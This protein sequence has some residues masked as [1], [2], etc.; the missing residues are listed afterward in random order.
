MLISFVLGTALANSFQSPRSGPLLELGTGPGFAEGRLTS[1]SHIA[2]G[3]WFGRYDDEYALGRFTAI[4]LTPRLDVHPDGLRV[5]GMLELRRAVDLLVLAP[6]G[7]IAAGVIGGGGITA[8][9]GLGLKLRRTR[10]LGWVARLEGGLDRIEGRFHP[11][12]ALTLGA[13]WSAPIGK[14]K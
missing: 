11:T 9:A 2:T 7:F 1:S 5:A 8:R 6:H 3:W 14:A 13:G 4:V 12:F 10:T